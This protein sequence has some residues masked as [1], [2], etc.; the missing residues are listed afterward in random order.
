MSHDIGN[1]SARILWSRGDQVFT[2]RRYSRAH[3][4]QFD[5]GA[6]IAGSSSPQ[7]VPLPYSDAAAIDPEEMFVA[8]LSS[9]HMLW[10]LDLACRAGWCVDAY[11]DAVAGVMA[12]DG[13][14]RLAMTQVTLR[15]AVAFAGEAQ[16]DA[17][18][19]SRLHRAA[20]AAC[21]IANSVRTQV[22][23]EPRPAGAAP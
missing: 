4:L 10:F 23:V 3:R 17:A 6:D 9:C 13:E 19:V 16:P 15:P 5:G 12:K 7:V 8:A 2:D 18:E 11:D 20:H 1:Y 22:S 21:F 14:G